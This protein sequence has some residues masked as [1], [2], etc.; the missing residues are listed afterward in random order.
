VSKALCTFALG[1]QAP[2]QAIA[3]PSLGRYA[4]RHGYTLFAP[5]ADWLAARVRP[6][7]RF[8]PDAAGPRPASWL[9]LPLLHWLLADAGFDAALWVDAD[10]VM[11]DA[12]EDIADAAGR[13]C[14]QALVYHDV[15]VGEVPNCGVWWLAAAMA[16][17]LPALWAMAGHRDH[18]WWEQAAMIELLGGDP[19][20]GAVKTG[21]TPLAARTARLPYDWNPHARDR[22]GLP[23]DARFLH[24]TTLPDR[25]AAMRAW[26]AAAERKAL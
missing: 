14:W 6:E 4:A 19:N 13:T 9:K 3:L 15:D 24:A 25:A 21:G 2:L 22:R 11:A 10:V 18:G 20:S 1:P 16:P 7:S 17:V 5:S 8:S 12:S 23:P 26:A